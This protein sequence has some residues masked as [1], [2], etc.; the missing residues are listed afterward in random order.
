[1]GEQDTEEEGV[2]VDTQRK[3]GDPSCWPITEDNNSLLDFVV[4][5]CLLA[6]VGKGV[7]RYIVG[8]HLFIS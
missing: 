1:M 3:A 2:P 5:A 7:L 4:V 8:N 6:L